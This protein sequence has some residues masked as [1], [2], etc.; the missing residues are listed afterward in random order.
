MLR[1]KK[2]VDP[3]DLSFPDFVDS[4]GTDKEGKVNSFEVDKRQMED[5]E[6]FTRKILRTPDREYKSIKKASRLREEEIK[7]EE[8]AREFQ[9]TSPLLYGLYVAL[10]LPALLKR[11]FKRWYLPKLARYRVEKIKKLNKELYTQSEE[12][13]RSLKT[14]QELTS[15]SMSEEGKTMISE[16]LN[17]VEDRLYAV[18]K[19]IKAYKDNI[20]F[21][22]EL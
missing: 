9:K 10:Y 6:T 21:L 12:N 5:Y 17:L 18:E 16:S 15:P 14:M 2:Y 11:H 4:V 1:K 3:E 13:I 7:D 20:E 8:R 22:K 19:S